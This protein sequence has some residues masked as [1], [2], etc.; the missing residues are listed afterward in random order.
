MRSSNH[1]LNWLDGKTIAVIGGGISSEREISFKTAETVTQ[2]L[3]S[4]GLNVIQLDPLDP[5][6]FTTDFDIAFNC[7]HGKWGE[8]GGLQGYCELKKS[9]I[10]ALALEPHRLA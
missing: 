4:M 3:V 6:F 1:R 8:D 7:L 2:T 5:E 10:L 9:P